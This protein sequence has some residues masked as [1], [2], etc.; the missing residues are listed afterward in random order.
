MSE[1]LISVGIPTY[2]RCEKLARAAG[3]VLSQTHAN[4][5]LLISDNASGDGT[6]ELCESLAARDGRVR[7]LRSDEN[8]GPT[9][10]FNTLIE[11]MHGDFGMLLSDDDWLEPAYVAACLAE[12]RAHPELALVCGR[13]S[14][15]R[16]GE[17]IRRGNPIQL[18]EDSAAAR[19]L[20]YLREVDENGI[21]YGLMAR[22][23]LLRAAP[24]RNVMANDWLLAAAVAVQGQVATIEEAG[25]NRELGGTSADFQRL[26]RTLGLPAWQAWV[27]HLVIAWEVLRDVGGRATAYRALPPHARARLALAGAWTAISWRSL[28]WH[29]TMPAFAAAGRHRWGGPLWRA[30]ARLTRALGAGSSD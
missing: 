26:T 1:P 21:F 3:S 8:R 30:Y 4:L 9:A 23:V 11:E 27:P 5:E 20:H 14:Y 10:N 13:A 2:N 28:A 19:V 16:D 6:R 22:D 24:L 7:Y 18:R 12:L 25:I 15:L 29:M 17:V